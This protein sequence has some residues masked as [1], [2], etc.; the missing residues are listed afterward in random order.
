M[1]QQVA[2][3]EQLELEPLVLPPLPVGL[4]AA[5]GDHEGDDPQGLQQL[6][7]PQGLHQG[8]T[9]G[10]PLA[11]VLTLLGSHHPMLDPAAATAAGAANV[12]STSSDQGGAGG[13]CSGAIASL[14]GFLSPVSKQLLTP[15]SR[16][17]AGHHEQ[18]EEDEEDEEDQVKQ[19]IGYVALLE[20]MGSP[21]HGWHLRSS[22]R[23]NTGHSTAAAVPT[24]TSSSRAHASAPRAKSVTFDQSEDEDEARQQQKQQGYQLRQ[25][26][27]PQS[28]QSKPSTTRRTRRQLLQDQ[29]ELEQQ[30]EQEEEGLQS[31]QAGEQQ[32]ERERSGSRP[33]SRHSGRRGERLGVEATVVQQAVASAAL[34]AAAAGRRPHVPTPFAVSDPS[35]AEGRRH[36]EQSKQQQQ[37][38]ANED[39]D[40]QDQDELDDHWQ[41]VQPNV[42]R[43]SSVNGSILDQIDKGCSTKASNLKEENNQLMQEGSQERQR[44]QQKEEH[45]Q[46]PKFYS[47]SSGWKDSR[48]MAM[49]SMVLQGGRPLQLRQEPPGEQEPSQQQLLDFCTR[50]T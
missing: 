22:R 31:E 6:L 36:R 43:T 42:L 10:G 23:R 5:L 27:I 8:V 29:P 20:G 2:A 9:A 50:S 44:H 41:Q 34:Q 46:T 47:S 13:T 14:K 40:E 1:V 19:A 21:S 24:K 39:E 38:K 48:G 30:Q 25:R 45:E 32:Q 17:L 37:P 35:P 28:G 4:S 26:H 7:M 3:S 49:G 12:A 11:P 15:V 33:G 18:D 16:H